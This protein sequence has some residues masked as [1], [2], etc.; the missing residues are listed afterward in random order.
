MVAEIAKNP[1]QLDFV[2]RNLERIFYGGGDLSQMIGDMFINKVKLS[3][4]YS[5]TETAGFALLEEDESWSAEDWKFIIP[6]PDAGLEFRHLS[7]NKYEAFMVRDSN[8]ELVQPVFKLHPELREYSLG[9]QFSPHPSK[10]GLWKCCGRADDI[11]VM[12]AGWKAN[13]IAMEARV[14]SHPNVRDVLMVGTNRRHTGL[15][16]EPMAKNEYLS[17]SKTDEFIDQIWPIVQEANQLYQTE[18]R[19]SKS[20]IQI[21]DSKKP[22]IRV[23]KGTVRRKATLEIYIEEMDALFASADES[24]TAIDIKSPREV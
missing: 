4:I 10:P 14:A 15:L 12:F 24:D 13:P 23:E 6:H 18:C 19:V 2:F 3:T 22:M 1:A 17:I 11:I 9:D 16:V 5:S 20:R 21:T 8:E 7:E